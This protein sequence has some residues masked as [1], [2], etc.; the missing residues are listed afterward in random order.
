MVVHVGV[1]ATLS[2]LLK[3]EPDCQLA[4]LITPKRHFILV[5]SAAAEGFYRF[6]EPFQIFFQP[7]KGPRTNCPTCR[8]LSAVDKKSRTR[9]GTLKPLRI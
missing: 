8:H 7:L 4:R 2:L 3:D 5:G 9:R 1:Q 6:K